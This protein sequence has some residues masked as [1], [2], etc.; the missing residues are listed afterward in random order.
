MVFWLG[1]L[2]D[3]PEV[4]EGFELLAG[5]VL[6]EVFDFLAAE[7]E[8]ADGA[9]FD[10]LEAGLG[11]IILDELE[12]GEGI[13]INVTRLGVVDWLEVMALLALKNFRTLGVSSESISSYGSTEAV[14]AA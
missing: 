1:W 2:K 6:V 14:L 11:A 10:F 4:A 3:W 9:A 13:P 5:E 12:A 8:P 7:T